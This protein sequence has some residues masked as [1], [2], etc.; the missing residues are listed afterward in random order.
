MPGETA[1]NFYFNVKS[2][3]FGEN[4]QQKYPKDVRELGLHLFTCQFA[5]CTT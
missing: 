5:L 1:D 2:H 3:D 4:V